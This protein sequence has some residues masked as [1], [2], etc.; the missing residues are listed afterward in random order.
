M[1]KKNWLYWGVLWMALI[2]NNTRDFKDG[3]IVVI[4]TTLVLYTIIGLRVYSFMNSKEY[5]NWGED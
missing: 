5:K 2:L 1:K 4:L 3:N